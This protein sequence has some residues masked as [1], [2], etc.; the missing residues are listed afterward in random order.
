MRGESKK[1]V[2]EFLHSFDSD[3]QSMPEE[4]NKFVDVTEQTISLEDENTTVILDSKNRQYGEQH[5]V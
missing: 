1:L 2:L 5:D 3:V 4:R